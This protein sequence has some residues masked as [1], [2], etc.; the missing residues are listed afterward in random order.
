[1]YESVCMRVV[2][3]DIA[4]GSSQR[5][6]ERNS[7]PCTLQKKTFNVHVYTVDLCVL[8]KEKKTFSV[9]VYTVDLHSRSKTN[10]LLHVQPEIPE[11]EDDE[12]LCVVCFDGARE[13]IVSSCVCVCVCARVCGVWCVCVCVFICV[14]GV[15]NVC[16]FFLLFCV[17]CVCVSVCTGVA[18]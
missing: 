8:H 12:D 5:E 4:E 10:C 3:T 2:V 7:S 11:D 18:K 15:W 1:M 13:A 14:C 17:W 9:H 6:R 16:V